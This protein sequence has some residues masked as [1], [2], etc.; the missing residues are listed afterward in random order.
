[1][2]FL[3][4][5]KYLAVDHILNDYIKKNVNFSKIEIKKK[6]KYSFSPNKIVLIEKGTVFQLATEESPFL[7]RDSSVNDFIY[8]GQKYPTSKIIFEAVEKSSL[9]EFETEELITFLDKE[10][11]L[12]SFLYQIGMKTT[13]DLNHLA[14]LATLSAKERANYTLFRLMEKYGEK[15]ENGTY[16]LPS[17]I[18]VK[19]LSRI[20]NCG[21]VNTSREIN[22]LIDNGI[23]FVY[24]KKWL[25][26]DSVLNNH[27][28]I[29]SY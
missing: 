17:W 8:M 26:I 15:Q 12:T 27:Q 11:L 6:E 22:T 14:F 19:I 3:E 10:K 20:S 2:T 18:N 25:M 4:F 5:Q 7:I 13:E 23:L 28:S 16:L 9:L 1:M 24:E 21:I 29:P